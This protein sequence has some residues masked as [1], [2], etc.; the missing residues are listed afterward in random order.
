[1]GRE[2][3]A[4]RLRAEKFD[5]ALLLQ[6][7]FDAAWLVWRA[8]IPERIGYAQDGRGI[9]LTKSI[10]VPK[11]GEIPEHEQFY[12]LELVRRAGWVERI[13][14]EREISLAISREAGEAAE[15]KLT[16]AGVRSRPR[17]DSG[18]LRVAIGAGASYGSAKCWLPERFAEVA[19]RLMNESGAEIILFGTAGETAVSN[20]II[21]GM[22]RKPIDLTGKT[23]IA[24]LPALLSRCQL[25]IGNDSGAM[26][27]AS[28]VGL[29]VVAI[30][31][32][33]D[34]TGT[35]PVTPTCTIV[36]ERS[37]CSPCFLRRCP[38]DHRCMTRVTAESVTAAARGWLTGTGASAGVGVGA[39]VRPV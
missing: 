31:G 12:Y 35:A 20:A 9:L 33:T 18:A 17:A 23:S 32:P 38:T 22:K 16:A 4:E 13:E 19:N 24:E 8:G 39:E 11:P 28:A 7:A 5:A 2:R 6:N 21:A 1:A 10:A 37:Y 36:Q 3:L 26:H 30:F 27:V 15:E 29:P 34:P 14:G 25:F